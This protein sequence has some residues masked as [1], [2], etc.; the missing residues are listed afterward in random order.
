ME[1]LRNC[2]KANEEWEA[3]LYDWHNGIKLR[4]QNKD[5]EFW[6]SYLEKLRPNEVLVIGAGTG[7]IAI[8]LNKKFNVEA[9]DI[10]AGRLNRLKH[11]SK[12]VLT[13]CS[14]IS[15]YVSEKKYDC[16]IVPYST[17]QCI[18][19]TEKI[20]NMLHS[21]HNLLIKGGYLL[22]D[23][24]TH[25]NEDIDEDWVTVAEGYSLEI[26]AY[27]KELQRTIRHPQYIEL[28]KM[29]QISDKE[30]NILVNEI[31]YND[32]AKY[33]AVACKKSQ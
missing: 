28:D 8:P 16:V 22:I 1:E 20:L 2:I 29:F 26:D 27:I 33:D 9:L 25:F 21:I 12:E 14:D 31:W 30:E 11:K 10:S 13:I 3:F 19:P 17:F 6:D 7:R 15:E 32:L 5:I 24:S 23:L 18:Y 4:R